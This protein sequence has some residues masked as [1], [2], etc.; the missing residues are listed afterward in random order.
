MSAFTCFLSTRWLIIGGVSISKSFVLLYAS[1]LFGSAGLGSRWLCQLLQ[2][3]IR[4]LLDR[5]SAMFWYFILLCLMTFSR[6]HNPFSLG[7]M[8]AVLTS[9]KWTIPFYSRKYILPLIIRNRSDIY[10]NPDQNDHKSNVNKI[11]Q[12]Q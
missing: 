4:F 5:V 7:A 6:P 10:N 1:V 12:S 2:K 9:L 8:S 11:Y 3:C